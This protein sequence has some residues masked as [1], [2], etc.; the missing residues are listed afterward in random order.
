[1]NFGVLAAGWCIVLANVGGLAA[2]DLLGGGTKEVAKVTLAWDVELLH[3]LLEV[4]VD[5]GF[6][7]LSFVE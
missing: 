7:G 1:M 6:R 3:A 5:I 2:G 4:I